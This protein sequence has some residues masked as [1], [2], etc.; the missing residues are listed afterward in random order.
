MMDT[1]IPRID[2]TIPWWDITITWWDTTITWW[3]TTT[4]WWDT[5]ILWWDTA[6]G[7][8]NPTVG[9]YNPITWLWA[10][11][12][13]II[14]TDCLRLSSRPV[15]SGTPAQERG[16]QKLSELEVLDPASTSG[17]SGWRVRNLHWGAGLVDA[18]PAGRPARIQ[19]FTWFWPGVY[20]SPY[21][22]PLTSPRGTG[23]RAPRLPY[24]R[25]GCILSCG[26]WSRT[27]CEHFLRSKFTSFPPVLRSLI[28][29]LD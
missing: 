3:D 17:T 26:T 22:V 6:I 12:M 25:R 7:Y 4:P 1:T 16:V 8:T 5:T 19:T 13:H 18:G 23:G 10:S 27:R 21:S 11:E 24:H 14:F 9:Y 2:T 20:F 28:P 29:R 15:A